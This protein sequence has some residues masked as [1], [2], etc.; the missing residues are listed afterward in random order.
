MISTNEDNEV[1]LDDGTELT[2]EISTFISE[3]Q[4]PFVSAETNQNL[5]NFLLNQT[6]TGLIPSVRRSGS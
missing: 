6:S 1:V 3:L 2:E 4:F 5:V